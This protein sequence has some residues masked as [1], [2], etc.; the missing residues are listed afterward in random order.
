MGERKD[1]KL[2]V[3]EVISQKVL[4]KSFDLSQIK[5]PAFDRIWAM[6]HE[7]LALK[8]TYGEDA[9]SKPKKK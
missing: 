5:K 3:S 7:L 8:D 1:F 2:E 4:G 6:A 9:E